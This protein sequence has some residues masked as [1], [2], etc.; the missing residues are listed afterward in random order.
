MIDLQLNSVLVRKHDLHDLNYFKFGEIYFIAQT[1]V[2]LDESF[3]I[4]EGQYAHS[5]EGSL[6]ITHCD[7]AACRL[8]KSIFILI[9]CLLVL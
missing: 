1:I 5:S 4:I 2:Y 9:F 3:L 8:V 6:F 7:S